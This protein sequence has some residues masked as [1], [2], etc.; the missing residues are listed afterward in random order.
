MSRTGMLGAT[1][2]SVMVTAASLQALNERIGETVLDRFNGREAVLTTERHSTWRAAVRKSL[3]RQ[4][5]PGVNVRVSVQREKRPVKGAS[6]FGIGI[7]RGSETELETWIE[8]FR[9]EFCLSPPV[10]FDLA[11]LEAFAA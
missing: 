9:E 11:T 3:A 6:L 5:A 10:G 7:D 2:P 4:G 1:R 8:R